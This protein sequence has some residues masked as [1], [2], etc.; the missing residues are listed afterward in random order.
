VPK[1]DVTLLTARLTALGRDLR[2]TLAS[3][4]PD[5]RRLLQRVL[6]GRRVACEAFREP[7]RRGYRFHA[8]GIPYAGAFDD[9][10]SPTR[11]ASHARRWDVPA[12]TR[13][14]SS[15]TDRPAASASSRASASTW[16]TTW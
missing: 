4:G 1:V 8:A 3:G 9:M 16:T 11:L 15:N 5:A 10:R 7:G 13:A 14:P 6:N 2:G 12:G